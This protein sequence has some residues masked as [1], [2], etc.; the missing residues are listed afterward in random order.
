MEQ[1]FTEAAAL[2]VTVTVAAGDHGSTDGVEDRHQHVDFPASAPHAL[3]CGGTSLQAQGAAIVSETVWND[4]GLAKDATGGGVSIEFEAPAYQ[5]DAQ[6]TPNVDTGKPGRGVPDVAGDADLNTG[7]KIL[8]HGEEMPVGGT[9][10]VAPLWAAL[11]ARF[12]Q[13]LGKSVGFLQPQIYSLPQASVFHEIT[14]TDNGK[15]KAHAG[16]NACTGLGSP[17]GAALLQALQA[18]VAGA[19]PSQPVTP[20]PAQPPSAP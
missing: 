1:I 8:A 10:A 16:W 5:P 2:G 4:G 6:A 19:A 3:A 14:E 11:V 18:S 15:Y 17:K 20:T 12:N 7:Y 9:S 13:S